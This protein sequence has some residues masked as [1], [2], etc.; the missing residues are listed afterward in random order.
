MECPGTL[1]GRGGVREDKTGRGASSPKGFREHSTSPSPSP[2]PSPVH[3]QA[4]DVLCSWNS[5]SIP[6]YLLPR[7]LRPL[8]VMTSPSPAQA[9]ITITSSSSRKARGAAACLFQ[10]ELVMVMCCDPSDT[11][12]PVRLEAPQPVL[13]SQTPPSPVQRSQVRYKEFQKFPAVA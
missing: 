9:P 11:Q 4:S 12:N 7:G 10:L 3:W 1:Y 8:M 5:T 2:S 6:L 13:S